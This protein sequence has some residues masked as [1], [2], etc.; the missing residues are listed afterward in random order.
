MDIKVLGPLDIRIGGTSIVPSAGKPRQLLA[1][2]ALRAGRV[3]PVPVLME[4]IWGDRIPRSAQTTL[5]TYILQL[6]RRIAPA[7]HGGRHRTAKDVLATRFGAYQ[8]DESVTTSDVGTFHRLTTE[9]A[10][11]LDLGDAARAAGLLRRALA[12]WQGPA[13]VDVPKGGVLDTEVLG[14]E[15]ERSRALEL[16]IEAE[17]ALGRHAQL[18]G[19]LR[20]LTARHPLHESFH[21]Q[22]MIALSR[23]GHTWRALEAYRR[24]RTTLVG[25][26]GVEPSARVQRLHQSVLNGDTAPQEPARPQAI[27]LPGVR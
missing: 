16:R 23:S 18:L 1:L 11:A 14:M 13:L 27:A 26:L 5:Q 15:E 10:S 12:L 24:L 22:L 25:E 6:R 20:M 4:E 2:L 19:E 9:G 21:A 7:L 17:L 8:L 3:V